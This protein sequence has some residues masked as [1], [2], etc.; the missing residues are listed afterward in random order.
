MAKGYALTIGLNSVDP[1]H[2]SG[3]S[4]PLNA[5]EADAEDMAAL[6]TSRGFQVETILT[7]KATRDAVRTRLEQYAE[8]CSEG[9]IFMLTYSGHGGQLPDLNN[10]ETDAQDETWC[11]Y[12]GQLVDDEIYEALRRFREG[13]RVFVASDSCHSG[14]VIR[15]TPFSTVPVTAVPSPTAQTQ[16]RV[17]MMPDDVAG[18]TYRAN[19]P[20]YD[21]ILQ[22]AELRHARD[23]VQAS[24]LLISGCQDNQLSLDGVANGL[25]TGTLL[26]VWNSG[27]FEGNYR[28]FHRKIVD[29]MPSTQTPNYFWVGERNKRFEHEQV[30]SI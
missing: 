3:W 9:D 6:A 24:V 30:F 23:K 8:R 7:K 10:D 26:R 16:T 21:P 4:G 28:T 12:D 29:R 11:L 5:C 15:V 22:N 20:Q 17:R 13:V 19:R 25:F 14:S 1:N 18:R 2:Y 27:R